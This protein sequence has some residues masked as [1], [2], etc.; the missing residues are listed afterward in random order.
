MRGRAEEVDK[1]EEEEETLVWQPRKRAASFSV[2]AH[3]SPCFSSPPLTHLARLLGRV[4]DG[5]YY[6]V[7]QL[8]IRNPHVLLHYTVTEKER[9]KCP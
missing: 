4:Q 8:Q 3:I 6:V 7:L 9:E 1:E 5:H 2:F